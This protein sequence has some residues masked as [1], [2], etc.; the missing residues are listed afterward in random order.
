MKP[1]PTNAPPDRSE[2]RRNDLWVAGMV[3]FALFLG[4]GVRNQVYNASKFAD[5]GDGAP[6]LA[7]PASWI[8]R[9]SQQSTFAAVDPGSASTFDAEVTVNVRP[10][11]EGETLELARADRA[12]KQAAAL[13]GYRELDSQAMSVYRNTPA[14]VTTYA[15]IAD[16]TLDAGAIGL[17]V[18]VQAQDIVYAKDGRIVV[19]TVAA[20]AMEWDSEQRDFQVIFNSMKLDLP[21]AT[22]PTPGSEVA[23]TA[24]ATAPVVEAT[25][26]GSFSIDQAGATPAEEGD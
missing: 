11:R 1:S 12:I 13:P 3:L 2:F 8:A 23:P 18:V 10:Q 24:A 22:A 25:P 21:G 20:D 6:R 5:L 26:A 14:V 16:P 9:N 15:Y 17:P 4:Y 19:T 7:Y